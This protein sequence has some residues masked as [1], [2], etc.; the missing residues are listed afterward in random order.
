MTR[1]TWIGVGLAV[2]AVG[3]IAMSMQGITA[4][5]AEASACA[6]ACYAEHAQCRIRK[7]GSPQCDAQ[8]RQCNKRCNRR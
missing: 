1:R 2:F 7:K 3:A 8:L 4:K 5:K 6:Q